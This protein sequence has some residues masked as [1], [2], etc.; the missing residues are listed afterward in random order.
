M[1]GR[2]CRWGMTSAVATAT[3]QQYTAVVRVR[4]AALTSAAAPAAATAVLLLLEDVFLFLRL[5]PPCSLFVFLVL[6]SCLA[7]SV[8][9]PFCVL[10]SAC[11]GFGSLVPSWWCVENPRK[12][13]KKKKKKKR[14]KYIIRTLHFV[15]K[16]TKRPNDTKRLGCTSGHSTP[17]LRPSRPVAPNKSGDRS[18]PTLN[19]QHPPLVSTQCPGRHCHP[20]VR[21]CYSIRRFCWSFCDVNYSS[22]RRDR[23]HPR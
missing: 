19:Y 17:L 16:R 22:Y 7:S 12:G 20:L 14:K 11:L 8:R 18:S 4:T 5:V 3:T 23:R 9:G 6:L 21:V 1:M 10:C 2:I 13:E 15:N